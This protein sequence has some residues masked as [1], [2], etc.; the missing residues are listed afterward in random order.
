VLQGSPRKIAAQLNAPPGDPSSSPSRQHL[1]PPIFMV[2]AREGYTFFPPEFM[3]VFPED[4]S[5]HTFEL[6]GLRGGT[7]YDRVEDIATAYVGE[8]EQ[9]YPEGPIL[10]GAYCYGA[11]IGMEMAERLAA[12]G[13]PPLKLLVFDPPNPYRRNKERQAEFEGKPLDPAAKRPWTRWLRYLPPI[14]LLDPWRPGS[15]AN[16][17]RS[18]RRKIEEKRRAGYY[19]DQSPSISALTRLAVAL[20]RYEPHAFRDPVAILCSRRWESKF[21]DPSYG[22]A[23]LLP[24]RELHVVADRHLELTN[25]EAARVMLSVFDAAL[26]SASTDLQRPGA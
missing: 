26:R 13:R 20:E 2:H 15:R 9:L 7:S 4:Q 5:M 21:R 23:K 12:R 6:P 25:P 10:L 1:R 14:E 19:G 8:I 3:G 22:W 24:H 16:D 17:V 18:F 11:L